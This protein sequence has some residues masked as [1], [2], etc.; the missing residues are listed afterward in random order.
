MNKVAI[1][2]FLSIISSPISVFAKGKVIEGVIIGFDLGDATYLDIRDDSGKKISGW[3][4]TAWCDKASQ[5]QSFAEKY[6]GKRVRVK[7]S[8]ANLEEVGGKVTKFDR[9]DFVNNR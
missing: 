1:A 5:N 8:K 7:C 9:I 3:C 2:L 6:I 4:E